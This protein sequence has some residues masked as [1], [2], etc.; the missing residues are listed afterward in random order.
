MRLSPLALFALLG[1]ACAPNPAPPIRAAQLPER[2]TTHFGYADVVDLIANNSVTTVEQ[3]LPLL[4]VDYRAGYLFLYSSRGQHAANV[5]PE[6]PRVLLYGTDATFMM[7]FGKSPSAPPVVDDTDA[8]QTMEFQ[9]DERRFVLREITFAGGKNPL[10]PAP[11]DNPSACLSCHSSD[12]RPIFDAYNFWPGFYGSVSRVGCATMQAGTP[13]MAGY[14]A[15]LANHRNADRYQFLPPEIDFGG[16]PASPENEL[17]VRNAV[18]TT[19]HDDLTDFIFELNG[20]RILRKLAESPLLTAYTPFLT[21]IGGHCMG[22]DGSSPAALAPAVDGFFPPSFA[23]QRGFRGFADTYADVITRSRVDYGSRLA[24]FQLNNRASA[25]ERD[26]RPIN[27]DDDQDPQAR[28]FVDYNFVSLFK[29]AADRMGVD[30]TDLSANFHDGTFQFS[31]AGLRLESLFRPN[32]N[33]ID[34]A[35]DQCEVLRRQSVASF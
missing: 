5:F 9:P 24:R 11:I 19:P 22:G 29:L 3:L 34:L 10:D 8:V 14:T 33:G 31:S 35:P 21:A 25:T 12:P 32:E 4:P 18:S 1:G 7:I 6:Q 30:L 13:E 16:C 26:R 15:F 2:V 27:F 20:R 23:E 28:L 17:T